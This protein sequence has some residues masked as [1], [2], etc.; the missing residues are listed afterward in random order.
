MMREE[1][2]KQLCEK[3]PKIFAD[4]YKPMTE[5]AM[6]WG[7]EVG[8][9]WYTIIDSLCGQIQNH[10]DWQ[11]RK[12]EKVAQVVADQVKEKFGGLRFYYS[13]GDDV[14]DGMVRMAESW[15]ANTCETCGKPGKLRGGGWLYTACDEHTK[16]EHLNHENELE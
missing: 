9:G 6:C 12:E 1:L 11:N 7:F 8:D 2:D 16:P 10:I 5:T 13:G 4:R 15:A 3:Y 14:V